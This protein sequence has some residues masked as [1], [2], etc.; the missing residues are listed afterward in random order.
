MNTTSPSNI[1]IQF[2]CLFLFHKTNYKKK[3]NSCGKE[4]GLSV[5]VV[6]P[7]FKATVRNY[8]LLCS[9]IPSG[10]FK[11]L[12]QSYT[13]KYC[14]KHFCL[15][16]IRPVY[17]KKPGC[18]DNGNGMSRVGWPKTNH[19]PRQLLLTA[20]QGAKRKLHVHDILLTLNITEPRVCKVNIGILNKYQCRTVEWKR[21]LRTV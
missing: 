9:Q 10:L 6:H 21:C 7:I 4:V 12:F 11:N 18:H 3:Q 5:N 19:I 17:N 16:F 8:L 2:W 14:P 20:G 13:D 1:L 15:L